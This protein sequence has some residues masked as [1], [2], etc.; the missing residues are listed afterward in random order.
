[1]RVSEHARAQN[2]E[3]GMQLARMAARGTVAGRLWARRFSARNPK[4][5]YSARASSAR[6]TDMLIRGCA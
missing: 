6:K 5:T 2:A 3:S 1:M 4:H